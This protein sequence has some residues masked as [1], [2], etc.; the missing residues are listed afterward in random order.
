MEFTLIAVVGV[1]AIVAVAALAERI[2]VAAPLVL[3]IVGIGLSFLPGLPKIEIGPQWVLAG[4][5]PPLLYASA[6]HMPAIDFRR[7]FTAISGLAV[8]LVAVTTL[9]CGLV[10]GSVLP[11]LGL[12]AAF[13]LGAIISPTDAVAATA[14][15]KRLGLPSRLLTILEGEGLVND[16]SSL[17]LLAS[18]VGAIT[19]TVVLWRIGTEFGY[20]VVLA[21]V[22][23]FVVAMAS[24]WVRSLLADSVLNTAISFVVPFLA[25][26][27]A[28]EAHASGVLAVVVAGL[29]AGHQS[30]R[31][32]RAQD[33]IAETVNWQT[34]AFLLESGI[35]LL[36]G[37]Q[38]KTLLDQVGAGLGRAIWIGLAASLLVI[39]LR[40]LFV[41]P[42][43]SVLRL[44][45]R[46]AEGMGAVLDS[47]LARVEQLELGR[48]MTVRRKERFSQTIVRKKADAEF[49]VAES[50][51]WRGGV[52]LAWSGMRGA[53]TV[54]AAQTLPAGTPLRAQLLIIAFVV[55]LT[56]LLVQGLSLPG[57][58]RAVK[59]P[60]DD[61]AVD[62]AEYAELIN[63][64]AGQVRNELSDPDL[65]MADGTPYA[66]DVLDTIRANF[67]RMLPG[68]ADDAAGSG[69]L[70]RH[71]E[72]YRL[73]MLHVL[74]AEQAALLDL[75][76]VGSY[77]SR[78]LTRAQR[79]LDLEEARLQQIPDFTDLRAG[80]PGPAS[81]HLRSGRRR[82]ARRRTGRGHA[83]RSDRSR[84]WPVKDRRARPPRSQP[85]PSPRPL[86]RGY[87]R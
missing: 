1:I 45:A 4:V 2:G 68:E 31:Y 30:P 48:R 65:A 16:A 6:V 74:A 12:A 58:I 79:A 5:L 10:F 71:R 77:S 41:A 20:A 44:E 81:R 14:I 39:V 75:R 24:M 49:A 38:L 15:G 18:A 33:R 28:E 73:L 17:V 32:L 22:V 85:S 51:G 26:L 52:V 87:P 25:Y 27:P 3:V 84:R 35:F 55:A 72:Q 19:G 50:F 78:T 59:V 60:G 62:R 76:S 80:R 46:R 40:M 82:T 43:V 21:V 29:V 86:P 69:D 42:L 37:L 23:G 13:A 7:D 9:C 67:D 54:A 83:F 47:M 53:V 36:M 66:S 8:L 34:I 57:V 11:G 63:G 70:M 56:T 64:L 61:A